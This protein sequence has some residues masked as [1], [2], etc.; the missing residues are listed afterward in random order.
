MAAAAVPVFA[1]DEHKSKEEHH[2][3]PVLEERQ[4]RLSSRDVRI[5]KSLTAKIEEEYRKFLVKN[6]VLSKEAVRR[7]LFNVSVEMV[8]KRH[9][10]L[11]ENVR[12]T[13]PVGGGVVDLSEFVTPLRGSFTVKIL[14]TRE[15]DAP[16]TELHAYFVSRSHKRKIEDEEFGAGC[17]KYMDISSYFASKMAKG[18]FEV[19]TADQRYLSVL[20][21]TFVLVGF[22]KEALYVGSLTFTDPRYPKLLC[23]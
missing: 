9:G 11:V 7:Q 19:Y 3:G 15:N 17:N 6:Q 5:P 10:P 22:E 20:G 16:I 23:E 21:G 18:G 2:G 13:A 1:S 14:A 8:A 4:A 12:V